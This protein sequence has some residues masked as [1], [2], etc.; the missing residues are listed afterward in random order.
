MSLIKK[1]RSLQAALLLVSALALAACGFHLRRNAAL[2]SSMQ[3]VH[4]VVNGGGDLQRILARALRSAGATVE[5]SRGPGIAEL[6]VPVARFS[7]DTLTAGGYVR[8]TEYAVHDE[9][10]FNVVDAEG[11]MLVAPQTINMSRQ[12]SYDATDTV[13]NASQVQE[14]QR[15]LND[16]MVQA[17]LFR[18][19]AVGRH[20]LGAPANASSTR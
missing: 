20:P 19:Q 6:N 11:R 4:L 17:I 14:I 3:R 15:S 10:Q 16:D 1:G 12:F 7:T 18:L 13:G 2:P 5:D 9:V 8:I